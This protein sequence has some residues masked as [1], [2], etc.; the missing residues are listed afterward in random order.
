MNKYN[1]DFI[2]FLK[3]IGAKFDPKSKEWHVS[4]DR[5]EEVKSKIREYKVEAEVK[6]YTAKPIEA[7]KLR[8][9]SIRMNLSKDGRFALI[10]MNLIANVNDIIELLEGTRK[11]VKFRILPPRR[12]KL[13]AKSN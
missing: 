2:R 12:S 7:I 4:P 11:T 13:E 3:S 6:S 10:R 9:G 1:E 5:I 8:V